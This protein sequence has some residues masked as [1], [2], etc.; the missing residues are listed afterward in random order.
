MKI[1]HRG[2]EDTEN[3][4]RP[5]A[6]TKRNSTAD[7]ADCADKGRKT[8]IMICFSSFLPFHLRTSLSSADNSCLGSLADALISEKSSRLDKKLRDSSTEEKQ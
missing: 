4:A 1:R 5:L 7:Y 6:A 2:A 3:T 8:T